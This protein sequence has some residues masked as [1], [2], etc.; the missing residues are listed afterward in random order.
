MAACAGMNG[1]MSSHACTLR[2]ARV[3][4]AMAAAWVGCTASGGPGMASAPAGRTAASAAPSPAS[5]PDFAAAV[6]LYRA[7]R[8]A[9]AQT[10][11]RVIHARA[12]DDPEVNFHL[13]RLALWFD[14]S[15]RSVAYLEAAVARAPANARFQNAL[16]DACGLTAQRAN[17]F[18]RLNWAH[19]CRMAY[20]R[21]VELEPGSVDYRWSLMNYYQ[22]APRIAGG[23]LD[24][25]YAEAAEIRR[26]DADAGRI[27]WASVDVAAHKYDRAFA[28]FEAML[29]A[30]PDDFVALYQLGRCAALSGERLEAGLAA[31]RR[32]LRL[33]L[34]TG[35]GQPKYVNVHFR[36]G[37]ILEKMGDA[38]GARAEYQEALRENPEFRPAKDAIRN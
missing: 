12:P 38:A 10:L 4:G 22:Q 7:G 15:V 1:P 2:L 3:L 25:A 27:A 5:S 11:F 21:A 24:R 9:E 20:Q 14:D 18:T 35:E 6:A 29:R 37:N 34:P 32:C 28:E 23:G 13:G 26:L 31:L 8:Y 33:P 36:M 19:R 17:V 16:G 30:K